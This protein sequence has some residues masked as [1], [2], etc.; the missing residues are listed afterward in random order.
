MHELLDLA[1]ERTLPVLLIFTF[2]PRVPAKVNQIAN[3]T[4][5][6]STAWASETAPL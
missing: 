3:V 1:V 6:T 4:T 5:V 2:R